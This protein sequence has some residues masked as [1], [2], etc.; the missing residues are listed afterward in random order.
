M[1][2]VAALFVVRHRYKRVFSAL[3][4]LLEGG[5]A[6]GLPPF[7]FDGRDWGGPLRRPTQSLLTSPEL[8]THPA[9]ETRP[10]LA[11]DHAQ[12]VWSTSRWQPVCT[13][14]L[15]RETTSLP[16]FVLLNEL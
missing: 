6:R 13:L 2:R 4:L 9:L 8:E 15:A 14:H 7:T 12:H 16:C 5:G 3:T 11:P 1:E 10:A